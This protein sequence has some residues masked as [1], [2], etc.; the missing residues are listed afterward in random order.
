MRQCLRVMM[1]RFLVLV[2]LFGG[3]LAG[4]AQADN[5]IPYYSTTLQYGGTRTV[6]FSTPMAACSASI[7]DDIANGST[8][9]T[10]W[11]HTCTASGYTI[12]GGISA[13]WYSPHISLGWVSTMDCPSADT[14]LAFSNSSSSSGPSVQCYAPPPP[15]TPTIA[16]NMAKQHGLPKTTDCPCMKNS[17]RPMQGRGRPVDT[18]TGNKYETFNDFQ[19][20]GSSPM[21]FTRHYD[22]SPPMA[23]SGMLGAYW[24]SNYDRSLTFVSPASGLYLID[25][26]SGTNTFSSPTSATSIAPTLTPIISASATTPLGTDPT[27]YNVQVNTPDGNAYLFVWSASSGGWVSPTADIV[28]RLSMSNDA[29]GNVLGWTYVNSD[30]ETE[31]Y[32]AGGQL[33]SITSRSGIT[34]TMSYG[35]GALPSSISDSFGH[36]LQLAYGSNGLLSTLTDPNGKLWQYAY[37]ALNNLISVTGPDAKVRTY[38]YTISAYPSALTAIADENGTNIDFT[39]YDINGMASY[40]MGG[41]SGSSTDVTNFYYPGVYGSFQDPVYAQFPIGSGGQ[42][43]SAPPNNPVNNYSNTIIINAL[44]EQDLYSFSVV[45]GVPKL[46][47]VARSTGGTAS[48]TYDANGNMASYTDFNGNVTT[49]AYDLTRN[50]ETSRTEASGTAQARTT[51]T[52]WNPNYRLPLTIAEP[53]RLTTYTY[54]SNGNC[55]SKTIADTSSGSSQSW[56]WTYN[57]LGQVLTAKAPRTD[58]NSTTTYTYDGSGN[59]STLTNALGQVTHFSNYTGSGYPQ[60]MVDPNGT[61]TTLSYDLRNRLLSQSTGSLT[62]SYTYDA[63]GQL[64]QV[65]LPDGNSLSYTYDADHRL[66]T[67]SDNAGDQITYTL[68]AMGNHLSETLTGSASIA[69]LHK[70]IDQGLAHARLFATR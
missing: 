21:G 64:I 68:D 3:L 38:W 14:A 28:D 30:D 6:S 34:Q 9:A 15:S 33:L 47:G 1:L 66:T 46:S 63:A 5:E 7:A 49:Y 40:T 59:L 50:L 48:Y 53:G 60:T 41:S 29:N 70:K 20:A 24:R 23:S 32:N 51:T 31:T 52:T 4:Q 43:Q 55:L 22:S 26:S 2:S 44:G 58:V 12:W 25:Y 54:D 62:T 27:A 42:M 17:G 65:T 35:A 36:T 45:L 13:F 56:S 10:Y 67:L 8:E 11:D 57:A 61:T 16:V 69:S 39:N 37:D 18:A 19:V